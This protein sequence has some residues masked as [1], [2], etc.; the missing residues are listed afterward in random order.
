ME[1][2]EVT[3]VKYWEYFLA[4]NGGKRT[5]EGK[6]KEWCGSDEGSVGNRKKEVW[7]ELCK[8]IVIV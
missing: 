8:K 7:K 2:E 3:K 6:S 5:G 1:I 4:V